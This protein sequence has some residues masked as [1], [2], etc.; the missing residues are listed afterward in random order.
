MPLPDDGGGG[1]GGGGSGDDEMKGEHSDA[2]VWF[3]IWQ[4]EAVISLGSRPAWS[5]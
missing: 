1:G 4:A 5:T 3:H 2:S